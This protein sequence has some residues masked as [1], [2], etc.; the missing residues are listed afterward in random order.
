MEQHGEYLDIYQLK[1]D[2]A[3]T[4]AEIQLKLAKTEYADTGKTGL[5]SWLLN[6]INLEG[7]QDAL[8]VDIWQL[9]RNASAVQKAAVE[10]K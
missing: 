6:G 7:A 4:M 10:E 1:I 8:R 3:P 2:K 5:I 9:P